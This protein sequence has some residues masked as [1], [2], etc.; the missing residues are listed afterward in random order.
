[1]SLLQCYGTY[2]VIVNSYNIIFTMAPIYS[3]MLSSCQ[4]L[5]AAILLLCSSHAAVIAAESSSWCSSSF[6]GEPQQQITMPDEVNEIVVMW[7][8][9]ESQSAI[10]DG[11]GQL[12]R[13]TWNIEPAP[14][15]VN[16]TQIWMSPPDLGRAP[17]KAGAQLWGIVVNETFID[18]NIEANDTN[19]EIGVLIQVPKDHLMSVRVNSPLRVNISP[20]FTKLAQLRVAG[21][22]L[23]N[24]DRGNN[25]T[26]GTSSVPDA[27]NQTSLV[28]VD[29]A[30]KLGQILAPSNVIF[31]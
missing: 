28:W 16:S 7:L 17:F 15:G 29:L 30:L 21:G 20:G 1:M 9:D 24:V 10:Y 8:R 22:I 26:C 25:Y 27:G 6:E 5:L 19:T 18:N 14:E 12:P 31:L 13:A 3:R 4:R 11:C 2:A 23:Q